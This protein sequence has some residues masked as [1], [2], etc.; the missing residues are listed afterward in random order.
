MNEPPPPPVTPPPRAFAQGTGIVLQTAGMLLF[1]SSCCVCSLT[2]LWDPVSTP[3]Q[4]IEQMRSGEPVITTVDRLFTDPAR[5]GYMLHAVGSTV[6]GL[7]MAV[8]GLGLQAERRRAGWGAF[9]SATATY[10]VLM[11]AWVCLWLGDAGIATKIWNLTLV[12]AVIVLVGFAWFALQQ[13]RATPPPAD[14]DVVPRGAKI[15]YS[16]YHDDPPD[17]RLAKELANRKA[18]LEAER[19]EIERL[20]REL[21]DRKNG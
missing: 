5:A 16:F 8:F 12:F 1:L 3:A 15:P 14:I 9:I 17:V 19:E 2:G 11:T 20:E 13:V 10:G 7:A 21:K 18:K 6:G 4:T